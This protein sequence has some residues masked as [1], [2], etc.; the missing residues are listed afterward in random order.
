MLLSQLGVDVFHGYLEASKV[1]LLDLG[2]S[3][4]S[5]WPQLLHP[6]AHHCMFTKATLIPENTGCPSGSS[7]QPSCPVHTGWICT[8]VDLPVALA[9]FSLSY[10]SPWTNVE[11]VVPFLPYDFLCTQAVELCRVAG[12]A[13]H[14]IY[15]A[16]QRIKT[17]LYLSCMH[18]TLGSYS[19][20]IP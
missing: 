9:P 2:E 19:P 11:Y 6:A 8:A 10:C 12:A 17:R 20:N 3:T 1:Y 7:T 15:K 18:E 16:N 14:R 5:R 4:A 13:Q